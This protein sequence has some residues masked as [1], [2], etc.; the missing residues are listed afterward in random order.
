MAWH[1]SPDDTR[2]TA[3]HSQLAR[4]GL[5]RRSAARSL[6]AVRSFYRFL[7][8]NEVVAANPARAVGTPT[9][10]KYLPGYLDRA[11]IDLLFQMVIEADL[12]ARH[13]P[14][15]QGQQRDLGAEMGQDAAEPEAAE[16]GVAHHRVG[17]DALLQPV[18]DGVLTQILLN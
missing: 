9:L 11:Q 4:R 1:N 8:R 10:E 14:D 3:P 12:E 5:S 18:L 7:H 16:I 15:R 13:A 17:G 2:S 6:S